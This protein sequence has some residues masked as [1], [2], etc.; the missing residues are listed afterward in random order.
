MLDIIE[1]LQHSLI[2]HGPHSDRIYLMKLQDEDMPGLLK[3]LGDL[4]AKQGYSK[5]FAK[6]SATHL[7]AFEQ[8]GYVNEACIPKFYG[9]QED[10]VFV[11]RFI[12][13][14][15]KVLHPNSRLKNNLALA[16]Q[17]HGTGLPANV[18]PPSQLL[19]T[20]PQDV[21]EMSRLYAEV[22]P[23]YPFPIQDPAYLRQTMEENVAYYCVRHDDKIVALAS[24]EMDGKARNVEMTDFATHPEATGNGYAI[25]LLDRM[26]HDM[27]QRGYLTSYT[28]ARSE[29]AGM[30]ITFAKLGYTCAG[31]L[32]NNTNIGGQIESMNVW[33]KPLIW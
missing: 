20:G 17:K 28:I 12:S 7:N 8:H 26:E 6:I 19:P 1:T 16:E 11:S 5:I 10:G 21:D 18:S 4:A 33:Y 22:F 13:D 15:R 27:R 32:V 25:F 9:G 31:T 23:T 24:A 2:Q 30:N 3:D 14:E 29:S